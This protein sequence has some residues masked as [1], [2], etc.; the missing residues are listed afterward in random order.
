[1]TASHGEG[2]N[3]DPDVEGAIGGTDSDVL[4]GNGGNGVFDGGD[5]DDRI[6]PGGG[7]DAVT[8]GAGFDVVS[9][10]SRTA[11]LRVD[12]AT[13]GGDGETGEGDNLYPDVEQVIGGSGNDQ[14]TGSSSA[15]TL[16]GGGGEDRLGGGDGIDLLDGGGSDDVLARWGERGH[17]DRRRRRRC[18]GRRVR[19]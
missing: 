19:Q 8:G 14:L 17:P 16:I 1:M 7:A 12:L 9:Y 2:D 4:S 18:A 15:N 13:P 3:I 5:G 10:A 6:D 11:P